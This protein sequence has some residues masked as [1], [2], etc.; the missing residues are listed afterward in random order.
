MIKY[1]AWPNECS[2]TEMQAMFI[3]TLQL[4]IDSCGKIVSVN[5]ESEMR[6]APTVN[7]KPGY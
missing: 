1:L 2:N 5:G 7:E 3:Y 6:W 4:N